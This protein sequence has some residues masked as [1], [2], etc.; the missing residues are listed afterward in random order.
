MSLSNEQITRYSRQ[1]LLPDIGVRGQERLG[2]SRVLVIGAGGLGCPAA[3]YLAAAGVGTLRI[4]DRETVAL[5]NLHRQILHTTDGVGRPKSES[6]AA[7]LTALNPTI[8]F[9]AVQRSVQPET[10]MELIRDTDVV[11]D[12][13][14]NLATRYLVND[15][16]VLAA[17]PLIYGG[18]IGLRG[19]VLVVAP[20]HSACFRCVFPEPP[21]PGDIPNC[22]DAGVLGAVAGLI[23]SLMAQE[24]LKLLAGFGTPLHDRLFVFDGL[25]AVAREVAVRR[26]P[27][28][29]VCGDSPSIVA[30][31]TVD[32][33]VCEGNT[34]TKEV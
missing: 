6:A 5:S 3:A 33:M 10:V 32:A 28:C 7:T 1:L 17:R 8:R 27:S 24:A 16:C 19:Q 15:A 29:A 30:P 34:V 12:G 13:S 2:A 9:E 31:A 4:V 25:A 22:Q 20:R 18:V 21:A 11:L 26:D 23:G 14:D